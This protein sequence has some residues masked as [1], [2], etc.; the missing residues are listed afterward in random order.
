MVAGHGQRA[1]AGEH[2]GVGGEQGRGGGVLAGV[3]VGLPV[4][5]RVL[6]PL[7][8]H[9]DGAARILN[10]NG[11][12]V[13]VGDRGAVEHQAHLGVVGVHDHLAVRELAGQ[14]IGAGGGDGDVAAVDAHAGCPVAVD[15]RRVAG[16]GDRGGGG[17]V[18]GAGV[19]V[20]GDGGDRLGGVGVRGQNLGDAGAGGRRG[21]LAGDRGPGGSGGEA[22]GG[23]GG[24]GAGG[25][26]GN[27]RHRGEGGQRPD[28]AGARD[29]VQV[30][31]RVLHV[32]ES[33]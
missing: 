3:G 22:G 29:A 33:S 21:H 19:V 9:H 8:Q 24:R 13:G 31:E 23:A 1:G 18:I 6:R 17:G 26:A 32:V 20:R 27:Q 16:Q 11:R 28:G 4:G 7:G 5:E 15:A 10:V 14:H 30:F 25:A 12:T 2:H